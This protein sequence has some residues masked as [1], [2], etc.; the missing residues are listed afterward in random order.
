[1]QH[2]SAP[3]SGQ[4]PPHRHNLFFTLWPDDATRAHIADV[5]AVLRS[6]HVGAGRWI[7]PE[8][9]HL[10]LRF[11]GDYPALPAALLE[12]VRTAARQVRSSPF[13]FALDTSG[14]FG[15]AR[16]PCWLGCSVAS[17]PLLELSDQ[18]AQALE[19]QGV[20]VRNPAQWVPHVTILRDAER[21]IDKMLCAPVRWPVEEFVLIDSRVRPFLPYRVLDRWP[22]R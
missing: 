17:A 6:T 10:T 20:P 5:A 9:Y 22:L 4:P 8:R 3:R 19:A 16:M 1:M 18:L 21:A 7:K 12:S 13:Y 11:L 15:Q 2:D 14:C